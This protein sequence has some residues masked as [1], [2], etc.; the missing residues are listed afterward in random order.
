MTSLCIEGDCDAFAAQLVVSSTAN[1]AP[2]PVIGT[3]AALVLYAVCSAS[4]GD[5]SWVKTEQLLL[6]AMGQPKAIPLWI[7]LEPCT[8]AQKN[9][10]NFTNANQ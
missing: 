8:G 5:A 2:G 7:F 6:I 10:D 1:W 3:G 9:M 4:D